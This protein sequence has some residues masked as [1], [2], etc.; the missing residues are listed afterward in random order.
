MSTGIAVV[1]TGVGSI[2]GMVEDGRSAALVRPGSREELRDAITMLVDD[3]P[4][5]QRFGERGREIVIERFGVDEMCENRQR[6]FG[7]LLARDEV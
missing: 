3:P 7:R 1:A 4:R 6:L 2:P 5:L